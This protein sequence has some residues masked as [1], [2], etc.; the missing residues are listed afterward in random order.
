MQVAFGTDFSQD[1]YVQSLTGTGGLQY[2][3]SNTLEG[4]MK[5]LVNPMLNVSVEQ[6]CS[7]EG[8]CRMYLLCSEYSYVLLQSLP[9]H[10]INLNVLQLAVI[11]NFG[12][13]HPLHEW[14]RHLIPIPCCHVTLLHYM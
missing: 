3:L 11:D 10:K 13:V 4:V 8:Y 9:T 12:T 14:Y 5:L 2:L 1:P 6:Y 7:W